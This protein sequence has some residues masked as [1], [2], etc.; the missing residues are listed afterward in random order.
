MNIGIK[1]ETRSEKFTYAI[2]EYPVLDCTF[3]FSVTIETWGAFLSIGR[4]PYTYK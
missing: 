4:Y 3:I 1:S 2:P